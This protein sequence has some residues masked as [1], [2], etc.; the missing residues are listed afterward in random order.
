[1]KRYPYIEN[2]MVKIPLNDGVISLC[3]IDDFDKDGYGIHGTTDPVSIGTQATQG[4]VR[5]LNNEV[6]EL[7]DILPEGTEVVIVD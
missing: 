7:F 1:M 5:M 2:G 4:C 3:D 6:E